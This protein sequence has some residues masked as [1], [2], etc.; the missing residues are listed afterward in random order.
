[1][2]PPSPTVDIWS[3]GCIM[4][5]LLQGKALFPGSDCILGQVW[6]EGEPGAPCAGWGAGEVGTGPFWLALPSLP[7]VGPPWAH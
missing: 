2:E 7:H 5:E 6:E 3:V 4:A 1:M